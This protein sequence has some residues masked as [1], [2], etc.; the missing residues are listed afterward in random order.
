MWKKINAIKVGP[1]ARV[2][3]IIYAVSGVAQFVAAMSAMFD[4]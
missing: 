4:T 2:F 3:A 1:V